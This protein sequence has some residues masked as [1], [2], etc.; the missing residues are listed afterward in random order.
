MFYF[1]ILLTIIVINLFPIPKKQTLEWKNFLDQRNELEWKLR[2]TFQAGMESGLIDGSY[3]IIQK[4]GKNLL[5]FSEKAHKE[6]LVP[7]ASVSKPFTALAI[8]KLVDDG[9]LDW[10]DPVA[11]Y[12]PQ[13]RKFKLGG[14]SIKIKHLLTHTSGIPYAG[15]LTQV[16]FSVNG[17]KFLLPAQTHI[18]GAKFQ[19]S[20]LNYRLL[21]SI[22]ESANDDT[23]ANSMKTLVFDPLGIEKY[24]L[25]SA[26]AASALYLAPEELIRFAE[27]FMQGG[28]S[29]E[30]VQVLPRSLI[31]KMFRAGKK[32]TDF[33]YYYAFGWRVNR[34]KGYIENFYHNGI[35]DF[36]RNQLKVYPRKKI[37]L[38][39]T[40]KHGKVPEKEIERFASIWESLLAKYQTNEERILEFQEKK[41]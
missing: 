2:D 27:F 32:Q 39:Y 13:M 33:K 14:K 29:E 9:L 15:K 19:Y 25:D 5:E 6:N 35:G 17:K 41:L 24:N 18:A 31:R 1:I 22:I 21:G 34:A 4:E 26:D 3:T 40:L 23:F 38:F 8:M 20:N 7:L 12:I 30:E 37:V 28:A 16:S 11:N 36:A 10:N